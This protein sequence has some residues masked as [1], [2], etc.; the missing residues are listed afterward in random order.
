MDKETREELLAVA[1]L[2]KEMAE[3]KTMYENE[4]FEEI[5]NRIFKAC[6]SD[7]VAKAY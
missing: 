4:M 5:A 1:R 7:E 3:D 6:G 2:S